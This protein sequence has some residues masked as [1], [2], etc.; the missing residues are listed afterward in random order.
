MAPES[1][2]VSAGEVLSFLERNT[3]QIIIQSIPSYRRRKNRIILSYRDP[4]GNLQDV[5]GYS[6]ADAVAKART[7]KPE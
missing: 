3:T 7:R 4:V 1:H 2:R 6:I 5:G